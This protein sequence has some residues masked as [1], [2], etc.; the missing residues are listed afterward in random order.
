[1][2]CLDVRRLAIENCP[3]RMDL[4]KGKNPGHSTKRTP[5]GRGSGSRGDAKPPKALADLA[6]AV[7][8]LAHA[9][10]QLAKSFEPIAKSPQWLFARVLDHGDPDR[11]MEQWRHEMPDVDTR[12]AEV[13]SRARRIVLE[14][15]AAIEANFR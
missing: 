4:M 5:H 2:P 13:L 10:E 14:S 6:R 1:M 9:G 8:P 12:G 7:E 11:A 3:A 15:R